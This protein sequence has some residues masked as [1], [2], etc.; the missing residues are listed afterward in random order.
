[1]VNPV[2]QSGNVTPGHLAAWVT[3]GVLEDFGPAFGGQTVIASLRGANFNT[4]ADQ[5]IVIPPG[6]AAFRLQTI[7]V[8]NAGVS[9]TTAAGGFYPLASKGGSPIVSAAQ[10]YSALT[11]INTLMQPTLTSFANT[12]RFSGATLGQVAGNN[13]VWFA[14]STPQGV[15]ATADLYLVGQDLS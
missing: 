7:L 13:A 8:C 1:M 10:V 11:T 4:T 12:T 15:A 14:L 2:Q 6:I 5:P 3:D 9:L